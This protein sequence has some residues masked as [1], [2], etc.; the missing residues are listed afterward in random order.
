MKRTLLALCLGLVACGQDGDGP[1]IP[2]AQSAPSGDAAPDVEENGTDY[3]SNNDPR[4]TTL[5]VSLK[6]KVLSC[7]AKSH[8]YDLGAQ[9]CTSISPAPFDCVIG[10]AMKAIIDPT[11]V[12]PLEDYLVSKA[13][14]QTLY[15][16][17]ADEKNIS[18]HFYKFE[19][20]VVQYR[21]LNV[22]KRP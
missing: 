19:N 14:G 5:P 21:K 9:A 17:T 12:K 18:L 10:D 3:S 16:C 13:A 22:A 20:G 1:A 15:S 11:T 2:E 7:E 8:F 6:N 4:L